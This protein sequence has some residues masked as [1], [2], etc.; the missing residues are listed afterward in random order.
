MLGTADF[1]GL[2]QW[3]ADAAP[4]AA[5]TGATWHDGDLS[6]AI[7]VRGNT[8]VQTG[9]DDGTVTGAFFGLA[10]EGMG[11][12]LERD[13]LSAGL[14]R[15]TLV[16][17]SRRCHPPAPRPHTSWPGLSRPSTAPPRSFGNLRSRMDARNG[18]H[19]DEWERPGRS[20]TSRTAR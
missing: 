14:R 16:S 20:R 7:A 12:V 2:E 11:G 5:G 3:A 18:G 17:R 8:F 19:D 15:E 4:G 9:G 13:D 1:T 6:Y 10:H